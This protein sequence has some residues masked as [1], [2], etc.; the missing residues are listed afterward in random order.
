M[1]GDEILSHVLIKGEISNFKRHSSGHMYFTLKDSG[2]CLKAVMFRSRA[3]ALRFRPAD[4]MSVIAQ[5][6]VTVYERDGQYQVYINSMQPDGLGTLFLAFE[7]LKQKLDQEGLFSG[8][9]KRV[10]PRFP[11]GV[12]IATSPTGAAVQDMISI[13]KRRYPKVRL[14]ISPILVQGAEAPDSIVKAL[15]Q[16]NAQPDLD[17]IIVGRGGGSLEELWAFNDERVARAIAASRLPVVSAVGH[18]T[19]FTIA[20]FVADLR[21]PTP[22]AAAEA[23]VPVLHEIKS[24][25]VGLQNRMSLAV[26]NYLYTARRTVKAL[27]ERKALQDPYKMLEHRQMAL[28]VVQ[29]RMHQIIKKHAVDRRQLLGQ[30]ASQLQALNPL[31]VLSRGYSLTLHGNDLL[32]R[33][34]PDLLGKSIET[35]LSEGRIIS[36]VVAIR[37]QENAAQEN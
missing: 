12:G 17:V 3:D 37:G 1:D 28:D 25:L 26:R 19:D 33:P 23:V 22:S 24:D 8:E 2:G 35:V 29:I 10:I 11:R 20:D 18:E 31:A 16:L 27:S 15:A 5:G 6:N 21:A 32:R 4:G 7:Q 36:K 34:E 30:I 13:I 14:L 9:R